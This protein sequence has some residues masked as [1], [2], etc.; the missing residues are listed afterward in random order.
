MSWW[1]KRDIAQ[2]KENAD[3]AEREQRRAMLRRKATE[4]FVD[5]R[6][7]RM[8]QEARKALVHNHFADAL[9]IVFGGPA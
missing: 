6:V 5:S 1:W 9:R 8:E 7:G 2:A 4:Q 3:R